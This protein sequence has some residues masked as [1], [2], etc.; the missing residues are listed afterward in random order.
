[1]LKLKHQDN[2]IGPYC[3]EMVLQSTV[4]KATNIGNY[5]VVIETV[6]INNQL[7]SL[8]SQYQK[9]ISE[10]IQIHDDSWSYAYWNPGLYLTGRFNYKNSAELHEKGI[11]PSFHENVIKER[12]F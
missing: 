1:M 11:F 4:T 7:T 10:L 6:K 8:I 2:L 9:Q 3:I 5:K 12:E